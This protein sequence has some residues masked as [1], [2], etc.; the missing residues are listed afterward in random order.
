[1]PPPNPAPD[2]AVELARRL[3]ITECDRA[4]C[5]CHTDIEDIRLVIAEAERR[6][7]ERARRHLDEL[8]YIDAQMAL[9]ELLK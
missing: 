9:L 4:E 3:L 7:I 5:G 1:M 8:G 2:E 6:G